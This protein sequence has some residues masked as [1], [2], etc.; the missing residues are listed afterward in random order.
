[1]VAMEMAVG[2]DLASAGAGVSADD[3]VNL[4]LSREF[5]VTESDM[6]D[7]LGDEADAAAFG[8]VHGMVLAGFGHMEIA[9]LE[10][11]TADDQVALDRGRPC[12]SATS[13]APRTC[14]E[15]DESSSCP[16]HACF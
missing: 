11:E 14:S 9:R 1:M 13:R 10:H 12:R 16:G 3:E 15:E 5:V 6:I 7:G 4:H 8:A 2:I